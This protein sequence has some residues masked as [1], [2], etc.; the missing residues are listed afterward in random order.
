MTWRRT[1]LV[2]Y[3]AFAFL[4]AVAFV[5][6]HGGWAGDVD[7]YVATIV[8]P[9]AKAVHAPGL[10][11][12]TWKTNYEDESWLVRVFM[13]VNGPAYALALLTYK[14]LRLVPPFDD[15]FPLGLSYPSYQIALLLLFGAAQWYLVGILLE[16]VFGSGTKAGY[17]E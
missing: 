5:S 15:F 3:S 1:L 13:I 8:N 9:E 11:F 16:R 6:N 17:T 7:P 10:V 2:A 14:A 4:S 12:N